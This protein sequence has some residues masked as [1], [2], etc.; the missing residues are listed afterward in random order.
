[1]LHVIDRSHRIGRVA[2][3]HNFC[4]RAYLSREVIHVER[5]VFFPDVDKLD[6]YS[7]LLES[8]P[9][10][11]VRI[12]I[13]MSKQD[14]VSCAKLTPNGAADCKCQGGHVCSEHNLVC[15][16]AEEVS[17]GRARSGDYL[18]GFAARRIGAA[19]VRVTVAEISRD[20][21]ND[22]MWNLSSSGTIEICS[23][24]AIYLTR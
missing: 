5:A 11:D 12:V 19:R 22:T 23:R 3:G 21:V 1:C 16:T 24:V 10:R 14:L 17:H 2:I 9:G 7:T 20:R 18:I 8:T 15:I 13:Q 4:P 6:F